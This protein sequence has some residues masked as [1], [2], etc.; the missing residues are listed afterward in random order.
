MDDSVNTYDEVTES[1][2]KEVKTIPTN[3]NEK[4][5]TCK[6]QSSYVLLTFLLITI[7]LLIAFSIYCYLIKYWSKQK[8]LLPFHKAKLKQFCIGSINWKWVINLKI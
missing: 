1:Y 5:I 6:T 4:N 3:F 8:H 2:D 7:T